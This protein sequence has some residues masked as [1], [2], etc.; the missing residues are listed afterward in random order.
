M[1]RR[2]IER[3]TRVFSLT[4]SRFIL[5][6]IYPLN[7][8]DKI[9]STCNRA[10]LILLDRRELGGVQIMKHP[11][12]FVMSSRF[13]APNLILLLALFLMSFQNCSK[14]KF[15]IVENAQSGN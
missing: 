10:A 3:A 12:S 8:M 14:A 7:P 4:V 15:S 5:I 1:K 2:F 11:N 6:H 9:V 13:F